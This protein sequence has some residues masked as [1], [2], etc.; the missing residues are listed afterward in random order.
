MR[1]LRHRSI[2]MVIALVLAL[3]DSLVYYN[4]IIIANGENRTFS[5]TV[6]V[7]INLIVYFM[8]LK[9]S[10][11]E[12]EA[13]LPLIIIKHIVLII[14]IEVPLLLLIMLGLH[15]AEIYVSVFLAKS[16]V[17]PQ[18]CENDRIYNANQD[19]KQLYS[20]LDEVKE[21]KQVFEDYIA[22]EGIVNEFE[23]RSRKAKLPPWKTESDS[24]FNGFAG[25]LKVDGDTLMIDNTT[26]LN[27]Y[28]T[29]LNYAEHR[30]NEYTTLVNKYKET[31]RLDEK[32]RFFM[33]QAMQYISSYICGKSEYDYD[34]DSIFFL[35]YWGIL[36][37]WVSREISSVKIQETIEKIKMD[38]QPLE[39]GLA[40]ENEAKKYLE[41]FDSS[42]RR[43][44]PIRIS[45]KG[46]YSEIDHLII[47]KYGVFAVEVKNIG[48]S[49]SVRTIKVSK[50]G[51]WTKE[52][53]SGKQEVVEFS[54]NDQNILHVGL[55]EKLINEKMKS[56]RTQHLEVNSVIV[57]GNN[58]VAIENES[59][60]VIIRPSEI[61]HS[62]RARSVVLCEEEIYEI[63]RII[64][65]AKVDFKKYEAYNY[66]KK[67][68][69]Q[70]DSLGDSLNYM[71]MYTVCLQNDFV[72]KY[73]NS[74]QLE[75]LYY[76]AKKYYN[77]KTNMSDR[78][79]K[80]CEKNSEFQQYSQ[81][82]TFFRWS[83]QDI[84]I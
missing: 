35:Y 77:T 41:L 3:L 65:S 8:A 59:N 49:G 71:F 34:S 10:Q 61:I 5:N 81:I 62:I 52:Y 58:I 42:L 18:K 63:C 75:R 19:I 30:L 72:D 31:Y 82:D 84:R 79:K 40:G 60:Q 1:L 24:F 68:V 80:E 21:C 48:E 22:A 37:P 83:V 76:N 53:S 74:I 13:V 14:T 33:L 50:D 23:K 25:C 55:V 70:L 15:V 57:I 17:N 28:H 11:L 32:S 36:Y 16:W 12:W 45:Y 69:Q 64:E 67:L 27:Y 78:A 9:W 39:I 46:M 7:L 4:I 26:K 54:A 29:A 20:C 66:P 56:F 38:L 51:R 43:F 6:Y 2:D 44:G 73:I 47:C